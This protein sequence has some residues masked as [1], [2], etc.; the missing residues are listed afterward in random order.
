MSHAMKQS[1]LL[2]LWWMASCTH[3][4]GSHT[5]VQETPLSVGQDKVYSAAYEVATQATEVYA[6]FE[7][8][9]QI[10]VTYLS[11]EFLAAYEAREKSLQLVPLPSFSDVAHKSAFLVSVFT[12]ND[13]AD[14]FPDERY[15]NTKLHIDGTPYKRTFIVPQRDKL[16][17]Q[18]FFP[19]ISAWSKEFLVFFAAPKAP[20]QGP[21]RLEIH[22]PHAGVTLDWK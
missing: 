19:Y 14:R 10:H 8:L 4:T 5:L 6:N 9:F 16:R 21:V 7:T 11:P 18:T 3:G 20:S 12:P 2:F 1:A 22:H 13:S 15:W 17:L